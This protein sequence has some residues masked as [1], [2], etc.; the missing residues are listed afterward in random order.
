MV[1]LQR[2]G[3]VKMELSHEMPVEAA[4]AMGGYGCEVRMVGLDAGVLRVVSSS[5]AGPEAAL[6]DT[7]R[8]QVVDRPA[9]RLSAW[10]QTV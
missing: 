5:D 3:S 9:I 6:W 10:G 2:L 4:V 7:S 8:M 1:Q